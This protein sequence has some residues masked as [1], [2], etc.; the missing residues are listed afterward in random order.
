MDIIQLGWCLSFYRKENR[1]G[2][3]EIGQLLIVSIAFPIILWLKRVTF[4]PIK[5]VI[6]GTSAAILAFGLV[7]FVQRAF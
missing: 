7:W 3:I 1:P 2:P 5:W 6:P 4:K